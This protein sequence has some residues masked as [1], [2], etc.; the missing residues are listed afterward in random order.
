QERVIRVTL[1]TRPDCRHCDDA[2]RIL[3]ELAREY[4]LQL[5][6]LDIDS[7][8]GQQLALNGGLL[9]PPGIVLDERPFCYGRPSRGRRR[10]DQD[11]A[12]QRSEG[13]D[14]GQRRETDAERQP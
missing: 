1:L 13:Q 11:R 4:P 3:D 12:L 6:T 2:K 9:F 14:H 8:A 5:A 10:R 7:A